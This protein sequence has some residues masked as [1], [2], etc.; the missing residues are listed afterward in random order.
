MLLRKRRQRSA[1]QL[2]FQPAEIN[3]LKIPPAGDT[4]HNNC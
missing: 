4:G 3:V 2:N 1:K